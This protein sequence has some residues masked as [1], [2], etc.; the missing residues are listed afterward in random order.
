[1]GAVVMGNV[2]M[3][4]GV[5]PNFLNISDCA[6]IGYVWDYSLSKILPFLFVTTFRII[7][8]LIF[9]TFLS[10]DFLV[11]DC[12]ETENKHPR[13]VLAQHAWLK[14]KM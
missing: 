14:L 8:D 5:V 11:L 9:N 10:L 3:G 2:F 13:Y 12:L 1:M 4:I 7:F 6:L